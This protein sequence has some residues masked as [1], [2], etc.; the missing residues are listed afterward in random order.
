MLKPTPR[1]KS[2]GAQAEPELSLRE[3]FD[4]QE[5]PLLRYAFSL[6]GRRAVAEE[7]V[8]AAFLQLHTHWDKVESP[9]AWLM[10]CVRNKAYTYLRQHKREVLG[11]SE[12]AVDGLSS[13]DDLPEDSFIQMETTAAVRLLLEE[14]D[15]GDRELVKLKYFEELK[16]VEISNRVGLT[17][18]NVGYRLHHILIVLA[19]KLR[20]L[21]IDETL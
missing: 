9:K 18:G 7:I 3:L 14:L 21:G 13:S 15:E 20:R 19:Q 1:V 2:T 5:G 8:Q 11:C 6:L 12:H 16:Y 17:V 10:R 4:Q